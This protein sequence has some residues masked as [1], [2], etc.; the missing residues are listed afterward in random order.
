MGQARRPI[1]GLGS[2][3]SSKQFKVALTVRRPYGI[4]WRQETDHVYAYPLRSL[5]MRRGIE[6]DETSEFLSCP[7]SALAQGAW[8]LQEA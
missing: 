7:G 1:F 5:T 8:A 3:L 4:S 6:G 2:R